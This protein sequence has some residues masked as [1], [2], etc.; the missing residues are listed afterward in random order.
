MRRALNRAVRALFTKNMILIPAAAAAGILVGVAVMHAGPNVASGGTGG[1]QGAVA[2]YA[3]NEKER[4]VRLLIPS[5]GVDAAVDPVGIGPSGSMA[6]ARSYW[7]VGWYE[8][9]PVPGAPGNAVIEGHLD[10]VVSP[11]AVFFNLDKLRPGD[12]VDITD[13]KKRT[14]RFSVTG[15]KTEPYNAP[16]DDIFGI[17][18]PGGE[19]MLMLVTCA[20]TWMPEKDQYDERLVVSAKRI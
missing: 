18:S 7:E 14:V 3:F 20:G 2:L 19:S 13:M 15:S 16:T 6:V 12:E 4:P 5:I 8:L 17:T 9:G 11:Y 10:E 1:A